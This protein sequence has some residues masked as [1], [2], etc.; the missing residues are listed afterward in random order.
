MNRKHTGH[1]RAGS[2]AI[3]LMLMLGVAMAAQV[4]ARQ[5]HAAV[6][7]FDGLTAPNRHAIQDLSRMVR[8]EAP[9]LTLSFHDIG[10]G[11]PD[12]SGNEVVILLSSNASEGVE[13]ALLEMYREL[14][15]ST[16]SSG[17]LVVTLRPERE[18]LSVETGIASEIGPDVDAISAATRWRENFLVAVFNREVRERNERIYAM[19]ENWMRALIDR[20]REF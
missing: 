13:P 7:M 9:D 15:R 3:L 11:A 16:A 6:V 4:A 2:F 19:H 14:R 20:V 5:D 1:R 8:D 17:T 18:S 12:I 10:S